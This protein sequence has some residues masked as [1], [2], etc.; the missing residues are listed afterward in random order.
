MSGLGAQLP[1]TSGTD[2]G[3]Y[4]LLQ[5]I[6]EVAYQNIKMIVLTNPGERI[7]DPNFGVGIKRWLFRMQNQQSYNDL[8]N[9]IAEQISIYLPYIVILKISFNT[10][11]NNTNISEN[12]LG[13]VLQYKIKGGSTL[14][15][16]TQE[17]TVT[18]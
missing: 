2:E 13:V 12:L 6:E 1:L 3:G 18:G 8:R 15:P 5:T 4:E 11:F 10:P 7:M 14:D 17:I 16:I 9:K